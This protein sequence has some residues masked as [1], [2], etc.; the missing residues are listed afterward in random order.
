M[1]SS[2]WCAEE[3]EVSLLLI[4]RGYV[5]VALDGLYAL[6]RATGRGMQRGCAELK[7]RNGPLAKM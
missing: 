3:S 7:V 4:E 1:P 5:L 2:R 6:I